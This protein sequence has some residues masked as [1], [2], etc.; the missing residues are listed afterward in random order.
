MYSLIHKLSSRLVL[1]HLGCHPSYQLVHG[2]Y[3]NETCF[4]FVSHWV[5][6]ETESATDVYHTSLPVNYLINILTEII[7]I[8]SKW[9]KYDH[10]IEN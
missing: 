7:S 8:L 2:E 3:K 4:R 9:L 10:A 1:F 5:V 6:N